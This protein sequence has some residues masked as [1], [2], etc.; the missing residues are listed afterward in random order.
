MSVVLDRFFYHEAQGAKPT[1]VAA[2]AP[3]PPLNE[4]TLPLLV[5]VGSIRHRSNE[6]GPIGML[7]VPV[8]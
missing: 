1:F 6:R 8:L 2:F 7:P 4:A 3:F 5:L